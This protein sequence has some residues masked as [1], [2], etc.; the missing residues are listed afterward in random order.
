MTGS[1]SKKKYVPYE[2]AYGRAIDD[3]MLLFI[4]RRKHLLSTNK[5]IGNRCSYNGGLDEGGIQ[6]NK[7]HPLTP[8]QTPCLRDRSPRQPKFVDEGRQGPQICAKT[9]GTVGAHPAGR[10]PHGTWFYY[11]PFPD[12]LPADTVGC[13]K[14]AQKQK[15]PRFPPRAASLWGSSYLILPGIGSASIAR[16]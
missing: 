11:A 1:K 10:T 15:L 4:L 8:T 16:I 2:V 14:G 7:G 12:H 9:I 3:M 5:G 6:K 13:W